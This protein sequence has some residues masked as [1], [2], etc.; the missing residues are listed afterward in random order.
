MEHSHCKE[1]GGMTEDTFSYCREHCPPYANIAH[2]IVATPRVL[3]PPGVCG[4]CGYPTANKS[5]HQYLVLEC[6]NK[7]CPQKQ[8]YTGGLLL[9]R[10]TIT[11]RIHESQHPISGYVCDECGSTLA[12]KKRVDDIGPV[13]EQFTKT[14]QMP[15]L[16]ARLD[17]FV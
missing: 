2:S 1:C 8:K 4:L 11:G 12:V 13:I 17:F 14:S 10:A 7:K 9:Y 15:C 16:I 6:P 3:D 5:F